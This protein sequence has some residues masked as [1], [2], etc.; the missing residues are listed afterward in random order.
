M[1]TVTAATDRSYDPHL[2]RA[3]GSWVLSSKDGKTRAFGACHV[4]GDLDT[5][6][7]YRAELEAIRCLLYFLRLLIR[8]RLVIPTEH[9]KI[10]MWVDNYQVL[11]KISWI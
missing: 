11:S 1:G 9:W 4:D 6:D 7:S 3:T 10:S 8:T 5:L 2:R